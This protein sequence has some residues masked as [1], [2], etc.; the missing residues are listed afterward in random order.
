MLNVVWLPPHDQ[1]DQHTFEL[2]FNNKMWLAKGAFT[3][4]HHRLNED[5]DLPEADGIILVVP[6]KYY[7][8]KVRWLNEQISKYKWVLYVGTG[9]EEGEF[10]IE[11]I[12]HRNK[13]VYYTTPH[14]KRTKFEAVDRLF[15]DGYAGQS[16]CVADYA[17]QVKNKPLDLYFGGQ[18]T[19]ERRELMMKA[20]KHIDKEE[21]YAK[22]EYLES[23]GFTQGYSDYHTYYEKMAS[24]KIVPCPSGPNTPDTFRSYEALEAMALPVLDTK[25]IYDDVSDYWGILFGQ[26]PP[27]PII[28][29]NWDS[30]NGYAQE[31]LKDWHTHINRAVS[32]WIAKKRQYAY[33]LV[34]DLNKLTNE[35]EQLKVDDKI[36]VLILT[37]PI[38]AHPSTEVIDQTIRDIRAVLP[39]SEIIIGCDGVRAEQE[40]YRE[41]YNEYK[42][43]LIW[44]CL[45]EWRNV[46]PVVFD[47]HLHQAMLTKR[48]LRLV[49]TPT[50][51]F[52]EHDTA[53]TPDYHFEW[54]ALV[55]AVESGQAYVIRFSHEVQILKDH[56][57]LMIGSEEMQGIPMVKTIQWSQ[58]PHLASTVFYRDII[59]RYFNEESRTM[60]ED[61]LHSKV[62]VD[63]DVD[64]MQGWY[65][66]RLYI[67]ANPVAIKG[68]N[69][70]VV[71]SI[72]RSY[73]TDGRGDDPKY[74]MVF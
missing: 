17:E 9:N 7:I 62:M 58:R 10:P 2:L 14:L 3:F 19:H 55:E 65:K 22:V 23:A 72:K 57:H 37:S 15:G 26:E 66:W 52:V 18:V 54:P 61:V 38:K 6:H 36:T 16:E 59:E 48:L 68:D 42:K 51:L 4:K 11:K 67:Y 1:W 32:W 13:I 34:A 20:L 50:V 40:H 41:N 74:S 56:E 70:I 46:L 29:D 24:A 8:D 47:E 27:M 5:E 43:R 45:H 63:Y 49:K 30:L 53:L 60:I 39:N 69:N 64:G 33:D 73:T 71:N 28:R 21:T 12:T 31:I 35:P 25:T 44:K